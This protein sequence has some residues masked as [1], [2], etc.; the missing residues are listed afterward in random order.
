M[1]NDSTR[2]LILGRDHDGNLAM[3]SADH[4]DKPG[5]LGYDPLQHLAISLGSCLLEFC[6]RFL[7]RR[8]Y[9]RAAELEVTWTFDA[10]RC[11]VSTLQSELRL[12][13]GL[14]EGEQTS[15]ERMLA[16]CPIHQALEGPLEVPTRV[17]LT[18]ARRPAPA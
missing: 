10:R 8:G 9:P 14:E 15:L 1:A 4:S 16:Q 5:A 13:I 12:P 3:R 17:R 2:S 6:D 18:H 7:S 11:R